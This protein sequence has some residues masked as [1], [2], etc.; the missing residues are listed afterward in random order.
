VLVVLE[1]DACLV[2]LF[3]AFDVADMVE[4]KPVAF[5]VCRCMG[6][7]CEDVLFD[8]DWNR[9]FL[10]EICVVDNGLAFAFVGGPIRDAG[11]FDEIEW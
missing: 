6:W 5:E 11:V 10:S 1:C 8:V 4:K 9:Y 2:E 7:E 3:G